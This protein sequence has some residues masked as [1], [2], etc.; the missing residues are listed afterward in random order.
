VIFTLLA[1]LT[2]GW[3]A[4]AQDHQARLGEAQN[5]FDAG[6]WDEALRLAQ[7]PAD[8]SPDLDFV[9]GLALARMER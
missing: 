4:F 3:S 6:G 5:A 7:G 9:A 2:L 8:Q 1:V